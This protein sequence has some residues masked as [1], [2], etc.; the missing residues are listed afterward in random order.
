MRVLQWVCRGE[1][2]EEGTHKELVKI[3]NGAYATLVHLQQQRAKAGQEDAD[4]LVPP[5]PPL[6]PNHFPP[7]YL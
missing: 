5:P 1:I 6:P 3:P 2:V 4:D 7:F